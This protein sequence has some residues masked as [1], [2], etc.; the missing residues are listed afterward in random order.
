MGPPGL[1][2]PT[3]THPRRVSLACNAQWG[4]G[5]EGEEVAVP[6]PR[7]PS[8]PTRLRLGCH[9]APWLDTGP[10]T[11]APSRVLAGAASEGQYRCGL[12]L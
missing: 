3:Q 6:K 4:A 11:S 8:V 12:T 7:E 1:L 2:T 9:P 10:Q 5:L